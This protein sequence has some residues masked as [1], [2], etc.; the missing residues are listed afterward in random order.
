MSRVEGISV[1][2]RVAMAVAAAIVVSAIVSTVIVLR[3]TDPA[4]DEAVR[5]ESTV[6][7]LER[8]FGAGAPPQPVLSAMVRS[9]ALG[10]AVLYDASGAPVARAG[11]PSRDASEVVCRSVA[12]AGAKGTLCVE[13][14]KRGAAFTT[15]V[16]M[17]VVVPAAVLAILAAI[18]TTILIRRHLR[19]VREA[20]ARA[21]AD[22]KFAL[23]IDPVRGETAPVV[24]S[25]NSLLAQIQMRELELLRR[26]HE[27]EVVNRD[28]ESFAHTISHD[29]RGPLGS[30]LG[31]AEALRD[32]YGGELNAEGKEYV[33]WIV[34]S[35]RQMRSLIDG[36]LNLSRLSRAELR[37]APV[38]LTAI[39]RGIATSLEKST[40]DRAVEFRIAENVVAD[41]DEMLLRAVLENL[42]S[43][44]WKF[45]GKQSHAT[46]EF[47]VQPDNGQ[48]TYYVRDNGAGFDPTQAAK[49]F[50]PFQR[51]HS[52]KEFE[53]TGIGL[54]TVQ[55][56]LQRHGGKAWA[57]GEP[58]HGATVYF[59]TGSA[60]ESEM[61]S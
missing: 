27:L 18:G 23:R 32:A 38:D 13:P 46:I 45:T 44:A 48:H 15:P 4:R 6:D 52:T 36:L 41:G 53:G 19:N 17:A 50:R 9:G 51:L 22:P 55:R 25:I 21:A 57:E 59:T 42:I 14:S 37:R 3:W 49:M 10:G 24:E 1:E 56:I 61:G 54:A 40:P 28:L 26:A 31:F 33:N 16:V 29:L 60:R 11:E 8:A 2:R 30:I 35:G 43:N 12:L 58:G 39:A 20:V 47:G 34:E 5:L 7:D